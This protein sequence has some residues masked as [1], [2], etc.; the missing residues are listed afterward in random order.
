[1]AKSTHGIKY[2][3]SGETEATAIS[4]YDS[5]DDIAYGEEYA[6]QAIAFPVT[7][8]GSTL[9]AQAV[10]DG[11]G[12]LPSGVSLTCVKLKKNGVDATYALTNI[13]AK[14]SYATISITQVAHQTLA[15]KDAYNRVISDGDKV[16]IGTEIVFSFTAVD[17]G[18]N[19]GVPTVNGTQ[20]SG[21]QGQ[22]RYTI[23]ESDAGKTLTISATAATLK[24]YN[25]T[26]TQSA[27]Q[28]IHVYTPQKE[29]G[30]DHTAN[31]TA[32]HGTTYEAE[33]IAADGY[34]AG[35]LQATTGGTK[36][37][38]T[39]DTGF[40]A[41]EAGKETITFSGDLTIGEGPMGGSY[42]FVDNNTDNS[43]NFG[44]I[45]PK[46]NHIDRIV[47][48]DPAFPSES[49]SYVYTEGLNLSNGYRMELTINGKTVQSQVDNYF[50]GSRFDFDNEALSFLKNMVGQTVPFSYTIK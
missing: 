35:T 7:V 4:L 9:Y 10:V 8:G 11:A 23:A 49:S 15:V 32:A 27:N 24:V 37:T 34:T 20:I 22:F 44:N 33:V 6:G 41:S 40:S 13:S 50:S 19:V 36:G 2:Q 42:G 48:T 47:Y 45:S 17:E 25:I 1:M 29:G 12:N 21:A 5:Q 30:T 28:T 14:I 26:I 16:A 18:Y 31:F 38:I 43:F 46:D 39:G 3:K